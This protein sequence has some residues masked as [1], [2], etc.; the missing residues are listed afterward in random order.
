[1]VS[2]IAKER[3]RERSS[4][5]SF[6]GEEIVQRRGRR[7]EMSN[8][9]VWMGKNAG[10]RLEGAGGRLSECSRWGEI[11]ASC[12]SRPTGLKFGLLACLTRL[13]RHSLTT[14]VAHKLV[15]G[16]CGIV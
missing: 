6:V 1:M 13:P 14:S 11:W 3:R 8:A 7:P 9:N 12:G 4:F 16:E 15:Q 5:A 10:T 2:R